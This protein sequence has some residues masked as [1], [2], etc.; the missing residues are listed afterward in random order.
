MPVDRHIKVA[1]LGGYGLIGSACI[2]TLKQSGHEVIGVGRSQRHAKRTDPDIEWII[3]DIATTSTAAWR[4]HLAGVDVVINAS[5]LLQGGSELH[6]IHVDAL[7]H[8]TEAL[9]DAE[10]HL[11]QISAAGVSDSANTAFFRA[12]AKGDA[13]LMRSAMAWTIL[14]PTLVLA[15]QAYGGTALLRAA[16]A[17]PLVE[18]RIFP[19]TPVQSIHIDDLSAAVLACVVGRMPKREIYD[20]TEA[21]HHRFANV[22]RKTRRWLGFANWRFSVPVPAIAARLTGWLLDIAGWFGW[23]SPFRTTALKVMQTGVSGDPARWIENGGTPIRSLDETLAALPST[24]Q[25]RWFARL[26]LLI[27]VAILSLAIFWIGT[28]L[29]TLANPTAATNVLTDRGMPMDLANIS[30]YGGVMLDM[31]LGIFILFR[32]TARRASLGMAAISFVYMVLSTVTAPDLW[33][34]PLGPFLKILP[35][36]VLCLMLAAILEER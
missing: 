6:A 4:D 1:V 31:V 2:K 5:G 18:P 33:L 24:T 7:Q 30:V 23:R 3:T 27:P 13:I 29:I 25:E 34:D 11:I 26:F 32:R 16:A 12:K 35:I 8:L 22:V 20:L 17:F 28:G 19:N 15:P 21:N 10:T 36:I 14:R 9:T